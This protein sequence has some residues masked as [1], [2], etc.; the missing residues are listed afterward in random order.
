MTDR[1]TNKTSL[2]ELLLKPAQLILDRGRER[3]TTAAALCE[4]LEGKS[5]QIEPGS[6]GLTV[7]LIVREGRVYLEQGT[8]ES[9]DARLQGSPLN[10]VGMAT[11]DPEQSI[12][13]GRVKISG[14]ADIAAD[15]Q[16]LLQVIRP[17][18][19]ELLSRFTGDVVAHEAGRFVGGLMGWAKSSR[20][21]LGRSL[22]EYLTEESRDLAATAEIE[23][24]CAGV[25]EVAMGV[26]RLEAHLKQLRTARKL[27]AAQ[28]LSQPGLTD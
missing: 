19:E 8:V 25:D 21:S 24:F 26:D 2:D 7:Y 22:A 3:S 10:L 1:V 13:S 20:H 5:L 17:D 15:Y 9:P 14:D 18:W 4:R 28:N 16:A 27:P 11:R 6:A 12:R 23:E